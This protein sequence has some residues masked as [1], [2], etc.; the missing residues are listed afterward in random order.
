MSKKVRSNKNQFMDQEA[1]ATEGGGS[2]IC[3]GTQSG[4]ASSALVAATAAGMVDQSMSSPREMRLHE[5]G[6][7]R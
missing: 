6:Y 4:I 3:T 7:Y 2:Q 5:N 1:A